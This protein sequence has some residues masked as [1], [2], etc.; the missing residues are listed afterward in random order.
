MQLF[1]DLGA[2]IRDAWQEVNHDERAFPGIALAA[3]E[4]RQLHHRIDVDD[5]VRWLLTAPDLPEQDDLESSFGSPPITVY[6]GR[7]FH[8]Q[9]LCWLQGSTTI[10]RHGFRGAFMV[11]GGSSVHCRYRFEERRRINARLLLGDLRL[12]GAEILERGDAVAITHD[13]V[14]SLFHLDVPSATLVVRTYHDG[15]ASPQFD[16]SPPSLAFD[17]FYRDPPMLRRIQ[18]LKFLRLAR[19]PGYDAAA[20]DLIA[21]SDLHTG[22]L[23][24]HDAH[25]GLGD[26]ERLAPLIEA[27][28]R[29]HG[30]VVDELAAALFED[31]RQVKLA[32]LRAETTDPERRFFLALLQNV[33]DR[34]T[35]Y[36][37]VRRRYPDDDPR[38]RVAAWAEALGGVDRIGVDLGDDLNRRLFHALL[39][40]GSPREILDRLSGEFDP[41]QVEAQAEVIARH[42]ERIK[43]TALAPLFRAGARA[44]GWTKV[45]LKP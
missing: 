39:D 5:V 7:R 32:R 10:H 24:L 14:H 19:G 13:L 23:A 45:I 8:I 11:L 1:D 35:L 15:D 40:G 22:W 12:L 44:S 20:A 42:C 2:A 31:L 29:R 38:A 28:R 30:A 25:H 16:Y 3:L 36:A 9:V 17:P 18:G 41:A 37:L 26:P 33:P 27:A 21:R 43:K 6:H 34:D 4:E